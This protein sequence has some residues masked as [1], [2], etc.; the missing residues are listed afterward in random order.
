MS[1]GLEIRLARLTEARPLALM[2]RDLI[3]EGLGWSWRAPRIA[4][5]IKNRDAV[6]IVAKSRFQIVGFAVM[7]FHELHAHLNL[8][9]VRPGKRRGGAGR[10]MLNWLEESALVAGIVRVYLEV[11]ARNM[12]A[13]AFYEDAGYEML[14]YVSGYYQGRESAMRMVHHLVDPELVK[15][16]QGAHDTGQ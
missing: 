3:E 6:V 9:A 11:R 4:A 8:L 16:Y 15:K 1:D 13:R 5:M 2:S 14:S 7:E 10:A 12:G